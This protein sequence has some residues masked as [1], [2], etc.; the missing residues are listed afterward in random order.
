M[1]P[2]SILVKFGLREPG[3]LWQA[4]K[5]IYGLRVSPKIWGDKRDKVLKELR[6]KVSG[7]DVRLQQSSVDTALWSIV[8]G[9]N[10]VTENDIRVHGYLVTYVDD[11]LYVGEQNVI[12][13]F[14]ER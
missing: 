7:N 6:M 11:F 5:A 10:G 2:P 8:S 12:S 9:G 13:A 3:E 1:R 14:L 4:D